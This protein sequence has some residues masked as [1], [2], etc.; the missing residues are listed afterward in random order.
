MNE[1]AAEVAGRIQAN[2]ED[3]TLNAAAG[4]FMQAALRARY[5]F[6]FS[7]FGR[8][9]IQYP[10]DIVAMQEL[11]WRVRPNLV[12]ETGVAHG[13]SAILHAGMLALLDYCDVLKSPS[14][15]DSPSPRRSVLGI[16]IEIRPHNRSAIEAHPLSGLID[17][18][19]GDSTSADVIA[20][21]R[22]RAAEVSPV[23]IVLDSNHAHDHVLSELR[24]YAPLTTPGS[25]CVVFDTVIDRVPSDV[26]PHREWRPGNSPAT[27]VAV[28][29]AEHPE[30]EVDRE[31]D[32]RSLI[33]TAP[34]GFLKR[35]G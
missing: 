35:L 10:Q 31:I 21:A 11:I 7:A 28:F 9:I 30:F 17:L 19:E 1:F 16:D 5:S 22:Q 6:N 27:A 23:L 33:S 18:I 4:D 14:P 2:R 13:G 24:A 15:S 20:M 26:F 3:V 32:A 34:G 12:I 25:Y 8:P 29:L